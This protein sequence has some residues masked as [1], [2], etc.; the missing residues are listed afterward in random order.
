VTYGGDSGNR[1][2][3]LYWRCSLIRVSVIRGSTVV[4][5]LRAGRSGGR[6]LVWARDS[7]RP[8]NVYINSGALPV[9]F[10]GYHGSSQG[11]R[12]RSVKL[13]TQTPSSAEAKNEWSYSYS[14]HTPRMTWTG[15]PRPFIYLCV[16][17]LNDAVSES[18]SIQRRITCGRKRSWPESKC[19]HLSEES[20]GV[21]S[22]CE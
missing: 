10:S 6:I 17:I 7:S 21:T 14:P 5:R 19:Q 1:I 3:V 18:E 2:F 9:L 16:V 8:Q 20:N 22:R 11:Q 13:T 4:S 15:N 12:G